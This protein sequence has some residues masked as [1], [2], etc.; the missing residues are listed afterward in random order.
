MYYNTICLIYDN[1]RLLKIGNDIFP[2]FTNHFKIDDICQGLTNLNALQTQTKLFLEFNQ[3]FKINTLNILMDHK[4][5]SNLA[6]EI[7]EFTYDI[8]LLVDLGLITI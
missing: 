6:M 5:P 3:T 8:Q 1:I 4:L 7:L 2:F